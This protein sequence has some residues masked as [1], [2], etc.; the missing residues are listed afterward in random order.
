MKMP[1]LAIREGAVSLCCSPEI[2]AN[3]A[4]RQVPLQELQWHQTVDGGIVGF[5]VR[6]QHKQ[7]HDS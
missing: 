2:L 3:S 7:N 4:P 6:V 1:F 5:H